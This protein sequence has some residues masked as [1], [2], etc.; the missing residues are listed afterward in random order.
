M[1]YK[2]IIY[3][4]NVCFPDGNG[5]VKLLESPLVTIVEGN[6]KSTVT[7]HQSWLKHVVTLTN[8]PGVDGLGIKVGYSL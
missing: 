2:C 5:T 7:V 1:D 4:T 8:S 6:L 3:I